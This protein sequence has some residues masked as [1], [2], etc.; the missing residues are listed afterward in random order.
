[1]LIERS[2][3]VIGL[4]VG[5][6]LLGGSLYAVT[7]QAGALASGDDIVVEFD[8]ADRVE[9]GAPLRIAGVRVGQVMGVEIAGDRVHVTVRTPE[10]IPADSHARI[11]TTN[12][13]GARAVTIDVGDEWDDLLNDRDEPV[14]PL[15]RTEPF[16][17]L[18]DVTDETV[19]LLEE[20]DA[21]AAARLFTSLADVTEG[22]REEVGRLLEGLEDVTG[23]V[24]DN[25]R[26]LEEF[27]D[28]TGELLEVLNDADAELLRT[29]DGVGETVAELDARRDDLLELVRSTADFSSTTADLVVEEREVI[30]D[31]LDEVAALLALVD[32][33]QV[34]VAHI[35]GYG[36]AAFEGFAS[37]G[38]TQGQ[39][40]PYWGN[41]FT[42]SAGDIGVDVV[43]GCGGLVDEVL[44][45]LLGPGPEC[46]PEERSPQ[47]GQ[48]PDDSG[49][50]LPALPG[51]PEGSAPATTA[52]PGSRRPA[53][54]RGGSSAPALQRF[55][56]SELLGGTR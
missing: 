26:E 31:I 54:D 45:Q 47:A 7:L 44:D 43:A 29:I 16:V 32:D 33:H 3:F 52:G 6:L 53:G 4:V 12:S 41:I 1:M 8:N 23:V 5:A 2:H 13:L 25:R 15:E 19:Q 11:T 38:T 42:S 18:P 9:A 22:Q 14:I 48:S 56:G 40:N 46:P 17:D 34:D 21:E 50:D 24:V 10:Q 27:L 36:G 28:D 20:A 35:L 51:A 49:P 39:D 37:V 55:L 30:D